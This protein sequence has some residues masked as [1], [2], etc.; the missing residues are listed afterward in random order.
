MRSAVYQLYVYQ[1]KAT[2]PTVLSWQVSQV[3]FSRSET[4]KKD[5]IYIYIESAHVVCVNGGVVMASR[6][7][8]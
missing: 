8:I 5:R 6:F 3:N 7:S 1:I 4:G 2:N